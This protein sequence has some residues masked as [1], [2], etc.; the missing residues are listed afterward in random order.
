LGLS[1]HHSLLGCFDLLGLNYF[2]NPK[3]A[4]VCRR[5]Y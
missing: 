4:N 5:A 2:F 3:K 1:N